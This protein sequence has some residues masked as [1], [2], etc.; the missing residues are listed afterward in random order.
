MS[1]QA[2]FTP[3]W[4]AMV[5]LHFSEDLSIDQE[6]EVD[7]RHETSGLRKGQCQPVEDVIGASSALAEEGSDAVHLDEISNPQKL[8]P[9]PSDKA[10]LLTLVVERLVTSGAGMVAGGLCRSRMRKLS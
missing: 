8:L 6:D 5:P 10:S 7:R 3:T 4:S 2:P 1:G 9:S